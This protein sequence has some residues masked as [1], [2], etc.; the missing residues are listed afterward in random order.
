MRI[1]RTSVL[2]VLAII[3]LLHFNAASQAAITNAV[4]TDDAF[5]DNY[6]ATTASTP[7]SHTGNLGF[8]N[9]LTGNS[10]GGPRDQH[11]YFMFDV[12]GIGINTSISNA[13][14][15]VRARNDTASA[16]SIEVFALTS[17]SW[18]ET[19]LT[20]NNSTTITVGGSQGTATLES[21]G[22]GTSQLD[23]FDVTSFVQNQVNL[24]DSIVGFKI[25][26]V[27][28]APGGFLR[29]KE[30]SNQ[31]EHPWLSLVIDSQPVPEPA[32]LGAVILCGAMLIRR[33]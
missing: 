28:N 21:L 10:T 26:T 4:L 5:I 30:H 29:S 8:Q 12:S 1:E 32:V 16:F 7:Q 18:D 33:R 13:T 3:A 31:A 11:V 14:L 9:T 6:D 27:G 24:S 2:A 20:H 17:D 23:A 15:T 19:T 25:S 22:A